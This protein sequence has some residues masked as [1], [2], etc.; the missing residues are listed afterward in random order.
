MCNTNIIHSTALNEYLTFVQCHN[1]YSTIPWKTFILMYFSLIYSQHPDQF[2]KTILASVADQSN[3][4]LENVF[5]IRT[6]LIEIITLTSSPHGG[7]DN[8]LGLLTT[9]LQS[10]AYSTRHPA[11][12]SVSSSDSSKKT[13]TIHSSKA[14]INHS[15]RSSG[16][17]STRNTSAATLEHGMASHPLADILSQLGPTEEAVLG[18]FCELVFDTVS[19]MVLKSHEQLCSCLWASE[20]SSKEQED[21]NAQENDS[22]SS[23]SQNGKPESGNVE[24]KTG[25]VKPNK[26]V[27]VVTFD[28]PDSSPKGNS[29]VELESEL[30]NSISQT[31]LLPEPPQTAPPLQLE[32][33]IHFLIPTI[34]LRPS[35]EDIHSHLSQVSAAIVR[36]L[37]QV[38]WWVGQSAR[39]P[40]YDV[41]EANG[42]IQ[43]FH[44][45]ILQAIE[46][47][48][49]VTLPLSLL[50]ISLKLTGQ[51]LPSP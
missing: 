3:I 1:M 37:H 40:L 51:F 5:S 14:H 15:G 29:S 7:D 6:A 38:T 23:D 16:I 46:G 13:S 48:F 33:E 11:Q 25:S 36:V 8:S 30:I 18:K 35:L 28:L 27:K 41:F 17:H 49:V 24:T 34:C 47:T 32:V 44:E 19:K 22:S 4:L 12:T 50:E 39:K 31:I 26:K 45:S 9:A 20:N 2:S 21:G 10:S 42:T 43:F